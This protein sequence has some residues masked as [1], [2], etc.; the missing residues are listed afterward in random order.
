MILKSHLEAEDLATDSQDMCNVLRLKFREYQGP[1]RGNQLTH[2][3]V[4]CD[5]LLR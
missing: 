2:V 5:D 3:T 4:D 1:R